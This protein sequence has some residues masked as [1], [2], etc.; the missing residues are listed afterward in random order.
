MRQRFLGIALLVASTAYAQ[1]NPVATKC[2]S[3]VVADGYVYLAG[4]NGSRPDGAV[5]GKL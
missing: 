4:Q 3:A 2:S 5:A 1:L